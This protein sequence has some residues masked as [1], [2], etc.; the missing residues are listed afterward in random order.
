MECRNVDIFKDK[1]FAE[2]CAVLDSE[3]KRLQA[4]GKGT[5]QK[6]AEIITYEAEEI[7]WEKGILGDGN[8]QSLLDTMHVI[9]EWIIF[10]TTWWQRTQATTSPSIPNSIG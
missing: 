10:C 4:A 7:L 5:T 1:E 8:P 6:K 2:C 9:Y 3:M